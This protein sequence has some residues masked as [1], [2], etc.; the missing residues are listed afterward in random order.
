MTKIMPQDFHFEDTSNNVRVKTDVPKEL[1]DGSMLLSQV[2]HFKLA[3]GTIIIVQVMSKDRDVL[4][5]ETEFRL[6]RA[7]ETRRQIIDERGER[8]ATITD[9]RVQQWTD[10]R[11]TD[12]APPE[13]VAAPEREPE[14]YVPGEGEIKWNPGKQTFEIIVAGEVLATERDK[15]L[16]LRI[17]AG[18]EPLP[19]AA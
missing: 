12:E 4:L 17:A 9:Y 8:V 18:S 7:V 10:W 14:R 13:P 5:H 11:S 1:I 2:R 15:E 19:K 6:V 3:A 16:A